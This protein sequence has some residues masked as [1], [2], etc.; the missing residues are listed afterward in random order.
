MS[1]LVKLEGRWNEVEAERMTAIGW[2]SSGVRFRGAFVMSVPACTAGLVR[3]L[4]LTGWA[5]V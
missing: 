4:G 5:P 2:P 1:G 3:L